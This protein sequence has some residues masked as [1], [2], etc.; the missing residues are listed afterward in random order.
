MLLERVI[1]ISVCVC[2][3]VCTCMSLY[4]VTDAGKQEKT[5]KIHRTNI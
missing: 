3:C 1:R 4:V 5:D 2:V